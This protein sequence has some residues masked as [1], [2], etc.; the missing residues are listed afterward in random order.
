MD[1]AVAFGAR[2]SM[3]V[4]DI[5]GDGRLDLVVAN[6]YSSTVSILLGKKKS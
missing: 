4:A 1:F 6:Q 5:K 3:A 2:R